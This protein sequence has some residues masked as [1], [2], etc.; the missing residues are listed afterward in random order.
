MKIHFFRK[1]RAVLNS[2]LTICAERFLKNTTFGL[3]N[4]C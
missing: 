2:Y 1:F 3:N 4:E